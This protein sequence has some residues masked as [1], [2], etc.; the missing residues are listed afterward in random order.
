MK[1][2]HFIASIDKSAGGTT[3]YMKLLAEEMNSNELQIIVAAGS[4]VD[5]VK[6]EGVK[7]QFFNKKL[8]RWFV[9]KKEFK[10]FLIQENPDL[11]HING[12]W[13][14]ENYLFQSV[15]QKLGI[16]IILSPHGMLEPYILNRN[17]WKKNVALFLYQK[18]ALLNVDLFHVTAQSELENVE[19]LGYKQKKKVIPNGVN[20]ADFSVEIPNKENNPKRIL[21]LSRIHPKK[22]IEFLIE[23]WSKLDKNIKNNWVV[24]IV[25]NGD[26]TYIGELKI[27]IKELNLESEILINSPI[28]GAEKVQKFRAASLFVLPT[29][30][31]NFG[32]VI[33]EA[34]ASYTPVITTQGTPWEE[35]NTNQCGWWIPVGAE[36]LKGALQDALN[37]SEE[38]LVL[39]GK[40]GRQ[41]IENKY[42]IDTVAYKMKKLYND[43]LK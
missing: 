15:A 9:L 7:T 38:E 29:Y 37:I 12:I 31:E 32:I 41:L 1:V 11:V 43:T 14:P 24:D 30:S 23:A 13:N 34:L 22:G 3:A 17:R 16:K 40:R 42:S 10:A 33:A 21:F 8:N 27:S 2:I 26:K 5:P 28:F 18:K 20:I 39:M 25:G 36:V 6:L 35:L 19:K 4:S